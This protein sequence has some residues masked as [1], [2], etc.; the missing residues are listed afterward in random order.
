M[1]TFM[2]ITHDVIKQQPDGAQIYAEFMQ[3]ISS[4]GE[5]EYHTSGEAK[6]HFELCARALQRFS[7][8]VN[9]LP[10]YPSCPEARRR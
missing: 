6:L 5:R 8:A 3:S 9:K 4:I 10:V 7:D 2:D 1:L